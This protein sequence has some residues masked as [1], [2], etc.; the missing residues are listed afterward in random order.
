MA[1]RGPFI[2]D[3]KVLLRYYSILQMNRI[4]PGGTL[5]S[6]NS[7]FIRPEARKSLLYPRSGWKPGCWG[8]RV[9]K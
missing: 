1:G 6:E 9:R 5:Q 7:M 8:S 2:W 4:L 3:T